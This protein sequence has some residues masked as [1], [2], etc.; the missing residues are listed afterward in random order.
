MK[1]N[2]IVSTKTLIL[3]DLTHWLIWLITTLDSPKV[4]GE[5]HPERKE[6]FEKAQKAY[7]KLLGNTASLA[8]SKQSILKQYF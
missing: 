6:A 1:L 7:E 2:F 4:N 5:L 8:V 3:T